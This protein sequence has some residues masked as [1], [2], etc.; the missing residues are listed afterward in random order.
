MRPPRTA[1][2]VAAGFAASA[3]KIAPPRSTSSADS[4]SA[5]ERGVWAFSAAPSAKPTTKIQRHPAIS[6]KTISLFLRVRISTAARSAR[7]DDGL[8]RRAVVQRAVD[9]RAVG[10]QRARE[11]RRRDGRRQSQYSAVVR[12]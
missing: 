1:T 3:V 6:R 10:A 11:A 12:D 7:E 9:L 4:P 2:A 8:R 5:K